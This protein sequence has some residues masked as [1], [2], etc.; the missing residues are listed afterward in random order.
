V[1]FGTYPQGTYPQIIFLVC[2]F[3]DNFPRI[4]GIGLFGNSYP[5]GARPGSTRWG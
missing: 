2:N 5:Q 4:Q 1:L 3:V